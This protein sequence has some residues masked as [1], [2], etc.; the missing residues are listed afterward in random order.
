MHWE[1]WALDTGNL[2][3][4]PATEGEALALVREL[5]GKG[6]RAE[7]LSLMLEDEARPVEELPPA[8]SGAKL[9]ARARA[10]DSASLSA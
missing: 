4:A 9:H 7:D 8:L 6:W 10:A 5:L 3:A 2:I 1:V